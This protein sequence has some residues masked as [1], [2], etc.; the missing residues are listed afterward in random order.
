[1]EYQSAFQAGQLVFSAW[2]WGAN[3]Q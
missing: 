2:H 3:T 1:M